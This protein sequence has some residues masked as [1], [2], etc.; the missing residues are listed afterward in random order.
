MAVFKYKDSEGNIKSLINMIGP[1]GPEGPANN[2]T[3]GEVTK[4][5]E[6][7]ATITGETPNQVLNLVLPQG[8]SGV[9]V[10]TEEPTD[11]NV[12]VWINPE[13]AESTDIATK[14]YVDEAISNI[15]PSSGGGSLPSGVV[16][17]YE[18]TE[19]PV[20]YE[21]VTETTYSTE[22]IKTNE[23]WI[24]GK[25][26]YRLVLKGETGANIDYTMGSIT[27]LETLITIRGVLGNDYKGGIDWINL[28]S[29]PQQF[30]QVYVNNGSVKLIQSPAEAIS[31]IVILE[32]TKTT[33]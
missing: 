26:I 13:G 11:K 5:I 16:V 10:G 32:Y 18:G 23:K 6:A 3:I 17:D 20:G 19:V 2:L 33:D 8:D 22:E 31:Y 15:E 25:P 28:S 21:E 1:Q 14:D 29:S 27:N 4:G 30:K 9:Y 7:E 24:D 12:N